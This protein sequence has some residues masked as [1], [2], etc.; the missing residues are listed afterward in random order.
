MKSCV[1]NFVLEAI[2]NYYSEDAEFQKN[3]RPC[4]EK[5]FTQRISGHL[6][7]L[8]SLFDL[9]A[10]LTCRDVRYRSLDCHADS[11]RTTA[12]N[13]SE[14]QLHVPLAIRTKSINYRLVDKYMRQ[15][16]VLSSGIRLS[17]KFMS[18]VCTLRKIK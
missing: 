2:T 16:H 3:P 14:C 9:D 11:D 4:S 10:D 5:A 8:S 18:R 13:E 12:V 17:R 7:S 1:E 15:P 6:S